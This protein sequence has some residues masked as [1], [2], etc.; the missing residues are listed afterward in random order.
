MTE[1]YVERRNNEA[2]RPMGRE[3]ER[4]NTPAMV[5]HGPKARRHH[6]TALPIA[7]NRI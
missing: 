6:N 7:E 1:S 2:M 4:P 3:Q 5:P